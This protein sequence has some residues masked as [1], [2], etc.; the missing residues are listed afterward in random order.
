MRKAHSMRTFTGRR[1]YFAKP[2]PRSISIRD[3]AHALSML[4][5]YVGHVPKHYSVAEHCVRASYLVPQ[6]D[7][8]W[9]LL[10][11]AAEA[12]CS[13]IS[14]PLK[15]MKGMGG[16]RRIEARLHRVIIKKYGLPVREP[17][18]IH[19]ADKQMMLTEQRDLRRIRVK[20]RGIKPLPGCIRPWSQRKAER[21][22]LARFAELTD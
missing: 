18:S 14:A 7:A 22:F 20:Y 5:R 3:I 17:L 1:V 21:L 16:Y 13:D 19:A 11:D 10:H 6:Q 8:L 12:Y 2:R 15:H 4:C 9:C